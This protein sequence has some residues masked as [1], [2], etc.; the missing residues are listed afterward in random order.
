MAVAAST[1]S[2]PASVQARVSFPEDKERER[3]PAAG[4]Q[5]DK[6]SSRPLFKEEK[7]E[8]EEE[9]EEAGAW[10]GR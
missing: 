4:Y 9:E 7:S 8:E 3:R 6:A 2:A 5:E 10:F 1:K